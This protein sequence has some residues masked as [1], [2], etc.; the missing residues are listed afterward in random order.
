VAPL[1]V[2][3]VPTALSDVLLASMA[4]DPGQRPATA[5]ELAEALRDVQLRRGWPVTPRGPGR[6]T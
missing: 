5:L 3:G 1:V 2:D 6:R 4:K